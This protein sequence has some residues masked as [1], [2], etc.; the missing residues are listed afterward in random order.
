MIQEITGGLYTN[1]NM[2]YILTKCAKCGR[3]FKR[4]PGHIYKRRVVVDGVQVMEYF[5]RPSCWP[6]NG[7]INEG[8]YDDA[9]IRQQTKKSQ[10][11]I[12]VK[13]QDARSKYR[14]AHRAEINAAQNYRYTAGTPEAEEFRLER[15]RK[16]RAKKQQLKMEKWQE[17]KKELPPVK[18][19]E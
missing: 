16:A 1:E 19:N 14:A 10:E 18:E 8:K 3:E 6:A 13:D 4:Y 11:K 12:K 9:K 7:F 2:A 5:D 15:N 17:E